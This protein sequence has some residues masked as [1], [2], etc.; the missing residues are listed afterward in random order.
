VVNVGDRQKGRIITPNILT[1]KIAK[2]EILKVIGNIDS[3][4]VKSMKKIYGE[5]KAALEMITLLKHF[6]DSIND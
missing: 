4:V 6:N 2:Y 3:T 1:C 5:G